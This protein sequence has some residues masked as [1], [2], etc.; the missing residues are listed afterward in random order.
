MVLPVGGGGGSSPSCSPPRS[1][2][3]PGSLQSRSQPWRGVCAARG[4]RVGGRPRACTQGPVPQ[5]RTWRRWTCLC[6]SAAAVAGEMRASSC[7]R[8]AAAWSTTGRRMAAWPQ[9]PNDGGSPTAAQLHSPSGGDSACN[10]YP[11]A[12]R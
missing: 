1:W 11:S 2:F 8:A 6:S 3:S 9:G 10:C 4:V 12:G 7:G 5:R